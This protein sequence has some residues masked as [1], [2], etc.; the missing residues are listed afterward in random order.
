MEAIMRE[1]SIQTR[2]LASPPVQLIAWGSAAFF[3]YHFFYG[4]PVF[5]ALVVTV[6]F[7]MNVIRAHEQVQTYRGWK[8]EWDAM[9][10]L[11]PR[12]TRWPRLLGLSLVGAPLAFLFYDVGQHGGASAIL[13]VILLFLGPLFV[14]GLMV[15]LMGRWKRR[16][17]AKVMPVTICVNRSMFNKPDIASAYRGLPAYCRAILRDVQ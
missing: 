2:L 15:K 8:R 5:W 11:P 4:A 1:P 14:L 9:S 17:A 12:P 7:L 6:A 3:G 13:G 10:G 16:K